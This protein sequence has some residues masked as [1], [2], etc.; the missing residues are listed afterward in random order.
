MRDDKYGLKVSPE[1]FGKKSDVA[2]FALDKEAA[3]RSLLRVPFLVD[4]G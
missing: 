4:F 2:Y 1:T 3:L